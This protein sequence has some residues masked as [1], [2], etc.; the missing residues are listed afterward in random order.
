MIKSSIQQDIISVNINALNVG[1]PKY[2]KQ[3]LTG[4]S[5]SKTIVQDLNMLFTSMDRSSGQKNQ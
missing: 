5:N 2:V 3:I 1:A 4:G